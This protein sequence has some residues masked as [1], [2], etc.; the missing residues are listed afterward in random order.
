MP[1]PPQR[2][3]NSVQRRPPRSVSRRS[4]EFYTPTPAPSRKQ[5]M[6]NW[7]TGDV[8]SHASTPPPPLVYPPRRHENPPPLQ[9]SQK[10]QQPPPQYRQQMSFADPKMDLPSIE[11][12]RPDLARYP[13]YVLPQNDKEYA[14]DPPPW[15]K[16]LFARLD[17]MT[18]EIAYTRQILLNYVSQI[19]YSSQMP[20]DD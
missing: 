9:L 15:M 13:T 16:D 14:Y 12:G 6:V 3:R 5:S 1:Q 7:E 10:Q 19:A 20:R 11:Q 18:Q 2:R 4:T 17:A 8:E